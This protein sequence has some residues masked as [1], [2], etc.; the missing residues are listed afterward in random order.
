MVP[1]SDGG[2]D[3][4]WIGGP[5]EGLRLAIVVC[6]EATDGGLEVCNREENPALQAPH[7]ELGEEPLDGVERPTT[8][9]SSTFSAAKRV[10]VPWRL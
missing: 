2:D 10:V 6:E 7:R 1:A 8:V 3:F 9:P 5:S 4:F